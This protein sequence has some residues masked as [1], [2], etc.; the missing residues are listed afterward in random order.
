MQ[1]NNKSFKRPG[2]A[3]LS[4]FITGRSPLV[5][6]ERVHNQQLPCCPLRIQVMFCVPKCSLCQRHWPPW[7][8]PITYIDCI[9]LK[10]LKLKNVIIDTDSAKSIQTFSSIFSIF[11]L[12]EIWGFLSIYVFSHSRSHP[13]ISFSLSLSLSL[14][15]SLPPSPNCCRG[16]LN[17]NRSTWSRGLMQ[18]VIKVSVHIG[19]GD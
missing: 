11:T 16:D 10:K 1:L 18:C 6:G 9:S 19:S 5:W 13:L 4:Q 14:S 2:H 7:L 17:L 15:P 8:P 12:V 3:P